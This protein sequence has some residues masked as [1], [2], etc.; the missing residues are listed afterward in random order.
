M[1]VT[2]SE[3]AKATSDPLTRGVIE[4]F[5]QVSPILDRSFQ[6][7]IAGNAFKYN[8]EGTLPGVEFRAVNAAYSESTG[9]LNQKTESLVILGGDADVDTFLQKTGGDLAD[10]RATQTAMKVKAAAYKFQDAFFNGDVATDANGF[11]GLKKRLVNNQVLNSATNGSPVLG[12]D[13]SARHAFF[14]SLDALIAQVPGID[15]NNGALYMNSSI[16]SRV[17]S[18]ARRLTMFD[19][20]VDNFGRK[21][22]FYNGIP[23]LDAGLKADGTPVIPQTEAQGTSNLASSI[24]AVRFGQD[25]SDRGVTLIQNGGIDVRDLGELDV[26]PVFR[27]RIEWFLGLALF[28]GQAAARLKGVLAA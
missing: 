4:T 18:S 8:E 16:L 26:K 15:G 19:Q 27:T 10:L 17:Q 9:A 21:V 22:T 23:L 12:S 25:E 24:Y 5:I 6:K 1:A 20:G 3:A 11:E 14:D 2:L 28:G 7:E 13:D